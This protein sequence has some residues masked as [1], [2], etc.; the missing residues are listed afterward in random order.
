MRVNMLWTATSTARARTPSTKTMATATAT[1]TVTATATATAMATVKEHRRKF[2]I[3]LKW[4]SLPKRVP[5]PCR[6]PVQ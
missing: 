6:L 4:S 1:A 5:P 2:L 3:K